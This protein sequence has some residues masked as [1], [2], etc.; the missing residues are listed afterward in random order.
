[1]RE[2]GGRHA[3]AGTRQRQRHVTAT[4]GDVERRPAREAT[5]ALGGERHEP[6]QVG[7]GAVTFAR[8]VGVGGGAEGATRG[9]A[10]LV[11]G[12]IGGGRAV[13]HGGRPPPPVCTGAT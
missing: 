8:D 3:R 7:A 12:T 10:D 4:G 5:E 6:L 1:G 9:V 11:G 13:G 2:V